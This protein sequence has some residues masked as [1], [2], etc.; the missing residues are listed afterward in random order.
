MG[1]DERFAAWMMERQEQRTCFA[2]CLSEGADGLPAWNELAGFALARATRINQFL[3]SARSAS[4]NGTHTAGI[5]AELQSEL[6]FKIR[7]ELQIE[8]GIRLSHCCRGPAL[9]AARHA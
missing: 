5:S 8:A 2:A 9:A 1:Q 7:F 4:G 3:I 6:R